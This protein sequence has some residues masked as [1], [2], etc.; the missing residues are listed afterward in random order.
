M[1]SGAREIIFA[2][3]KLDNFRSDNFFYD[4]QGPGKFNAS[5]RENC[6]DCSA[7]GKMIVGRAPLDR[8]VRSSG[9]PKKSRRINRQ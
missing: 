6:K 7:L 4:R 2:I 8:R 9:L 5:F 3:Y 1:V